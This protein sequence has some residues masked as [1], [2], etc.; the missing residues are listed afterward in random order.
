MQHFWFFPVSLIFALT[1]RIPKPTIP[2]P[3]NPFRDILI[4]IPY[5]AKS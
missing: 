5:Q 1:A 2:K 4:S 3:D